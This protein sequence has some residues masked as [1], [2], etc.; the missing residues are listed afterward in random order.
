MNEE[1][2]LEIAATAFIKEIS[3]EIKN[4][5]AGVTAEAKQFLEIGLT[6][7]IQNQYNRFRS[8]KTILRG[9]TPNYFYDVYH[10]LN[11]KSHKHQAITT[12]IDST[13]EK[14]NYITVIG[15]GGSGKS[16]L[17]KH[18]FLRAL[19]EKRAIPVFIELRHLT[20]SKNSIESHIKDKILEQK[21]SESTKILE[22]MLSSGK[23]LFFL[24]GYDEISGEYKKNITESINGFTEKYRNNK[25][26]LTTRPY[27]DIDLL[28]L[29]HNYHIEQLKDHDIASFIERQ[30]REEP[31]LA[32]KIKKSIKESKSKHIA[33]FL[34]NPLLLSLYILTYQSNS[35][36][37]TKKYVFYRRVINALFSEHDSK[38]KLGFERETKC[39]LQQED[40]EKVLKA[41]CF[42]SYFDEAFSFEHDELISR[43][44]KVKT[45]IS[46][47]RFSPTDFTSD[48]KIAISLW[49]E[50]GGITTF[51]HR[52]LQEYFAALFIKDL[53]DQNKEQ[54]Y[55]QILK[56][57]ESIATL[58]EI[59]NFLSLCEEMDEASFNKNLAIPILEE[60]RK[61][62]TGR[63]T[64]SKFVTFFSS[65][66]NLRHITSETKKITN[67]A[68]TMV[69]RKVYKSIY[70]HLPFTIKLHDLMTQLDPEELFP[71]GIPPS[72]RR[73]Y[74]TFLFSKTKGLKKKVIEVLKEKGA[75]SLAQK[76][77]DYIDKEIDKR[78]KKIALQ[79]KT[80]TGL[81]NMIKK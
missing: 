54:V 76:F 57:L 46:E 38:T 7:Y 4:A 20:N 39:R 66:I 45:E 34:K 12:S 72:E 49:I 8:V 30:L 42:V 75:Y 16:T 27:S 1:K 10:P 53:D 3:A 14:S 62:L 15:E 50:D 31:E 24:D 17:V 70:F 2:L 9:N 56:K 32:E 40:F 71:E 6:D 11:I 65:G 18:L 59:E 23:F 73:D 35:S 28:P 13:F 25:Y 63:D 69:N 79:N 52:S 37:P 68:H 19:G 64:L 58:N 74:A 26:L 36:I 22:R 77:L 47:L 33:S 81:I 61:E 80:N 44:D 51:A 60:L 29:F 21:L 48:M 55:A 5:Y 67:I 78:S 43:L 41:F